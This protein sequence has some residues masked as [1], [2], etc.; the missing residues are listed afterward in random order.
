M[1]T[2]FIPCNT[3]ALSHYFNKGLLV[4]SVVLDNRPHD[5]QN[6]FPDYLLLSSYK[7]IKNCNAAI[8]IVLTEAE[9]TQLTQI[10][11]GFYLLSVVLPI[12]R[13]KN[14]W[15]L[16]Q[17]Q[18]ETT[19]WNI[20]DGAGFLNKS[21]AVT[22]P[23]KNNLV[24]EFEFSSE[25]S[26]PDKPEIS[27][28]LKLFD[29][30]LGSLALMRIAG[31]TDLNYSYNYMFTLSG[32]NSVIHHELQTTIKSETDFSS[33][34]ID[35]LTNK[36]NDW[37]ILFQY[38]QNPLTDE[39]IINLAKKEKITIKK[40]FGSL[41]LDGIPTDSVFFYL[42]LM[43]IYGVGG[44]K[45]EYDLINL[46]LSSKTYLENRE[47]VLFLFGHHLGYSKLFNGYKVSNT[48][49]PVKYDLVSKINYYTIE[50]IYQYVF[51]NIEKS[52]F[53]PY[54]DEWV[55]NKP[56][57]KHRGYETYKILDEV[58]KLKKKKSYSER[59]SEQFSNEIVDRVLLKINESLPSYLNLDNSR[60]LSLVTSDIKDILGKQISLVA[61]VVGKEAEEFY[62]N[63]EEI[64]ENRSIPGNN[65]KQSNNSDAYP[66]KSATAKNSNTY[67]SPKPFSN[68]PIQKTSKYSST[69]S[70]EKLL[71]NDEVSTPNNDN[72]LLKHKEVLVVPK[73]RNRGTKTKSSTNKNSGIKNSTASDNPPQNNVATGNLF[74]ENQ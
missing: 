14:V 26:L 50:T 65:D 58:V 56:V 44:V 55:P 28:K 46:L 35:F 24:S 18:L 49:Y 38:F 13:I 16:Q 67:I 60:F 23:L 45:S 64:P 3:T 42:T 47:E 9:S 6:L 30:M 27:Q 19:L 15:F 12:S 71:V 31:G 68:K 10:S 41:L 51:N 74:D 33:K 61:S 11:T 25:L 4:P 39:E 34:F 7:W 5:T 59:Y 29:Q 8:E 54:L 66:E 1:T 43:K 70:E 63:T 52:D 57:Q 73:K 36:P 20:N 62:S 72:T 17:E 40:Q 21:L 22:E 48:F 32:F 53:F 2:Y 69:N 37:E